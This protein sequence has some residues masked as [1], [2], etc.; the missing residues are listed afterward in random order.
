MAK[1]SFRL[2]M[3]E[4]ELLA[5]EADMVVVPGSEGDFGVLPGHAPLIS[6][7]RPGVLEVYQNHKV[8]QRFLVAGGFAEVTPE[9][10]T[11]LADEAVRFEEMTVAQLDERERA[12]R[13]DI[14]EADTPA[15]KAAAEKSLAIVQDLKRAQAFYASR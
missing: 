8:E 1:V 12:A 6:T 3:P 10:C 7:V 15:E 9:R 2:V 11:V 13:N 5:T 14:T 4:R